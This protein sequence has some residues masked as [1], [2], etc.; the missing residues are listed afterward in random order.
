GPVDQIRMLGDQLGPRRRDHL[1]ALGERHSEDFE[2][3]IEDR[4]DA[5]HGRRDGVV[6]DVWREHR[7]GKVYTP[8]RKR[9]TPLD[10]QPDPKVRVQGNDPVTTASTAPAAKPSRRRSPGSA[11]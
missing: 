5:A 4:K 3:G 7:R 9:G 1:L 10:P 6:R 2:Q 11:A 8:Y